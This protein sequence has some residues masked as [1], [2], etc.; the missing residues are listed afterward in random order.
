MMSIR[1]TLVALLLAGSASAVAA[2][3]PE[4]A[5]WDVNAAHG[6][7]KTIR[8]TTDEGTWMD[9]DVSPDGRQIAFSLLGDI[10]LLPIA[11][12]SAK[13]ISS[14]PAWDVQP[15]FSPDGN[16]IAYTSD[17]AGGNNLWRMSVSGT[18]PT[19]VSKEEFRLLNIP[20]GT[21]DGQYLIGRNHYTGER[22]L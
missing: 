6:K 11:G 1:V 12:G 21:A 9:L 20:A 8:F 14:G 3:K 7:T 10:Y 18:N 5:K 15:R 2:D 19:Q 17:R 4:P 13:R 22:T 16:E